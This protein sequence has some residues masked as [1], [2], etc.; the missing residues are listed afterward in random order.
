VIK[1]ANLPYLRK[2]GASNADQIYFSRV[3]SER[4]IMIDLYGRR[5]PLDAVVTA[6]TEVVFDLPGIAEETT[7]GRRR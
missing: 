3:M 7:R 4:L 1:A 6:R 2:K 5:R